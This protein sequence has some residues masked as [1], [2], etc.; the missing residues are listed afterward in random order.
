MSLEEKELAWNNEE[1]EEEIHE[2][3]ESKQLTDEEKK[4]A[5]IE[6]EKIELEKEKQIQLET[7]EITTMA[8][9]KGYKV[10]IHGRNFINT[11]PLLSIRF[12]Y[13]NGEVDKSVIPVFKNSKLLGVVLPDM[14]EL[15]P[16]G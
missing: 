8:K 3:V 10:F 15:V 5:D 7:E 1:P 6:R 4:K 13:N 9:R 16:I 11:E 2:Q 12:S 14:G